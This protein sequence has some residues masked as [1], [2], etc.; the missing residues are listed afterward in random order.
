MPL[1][2]YRLLAVLLALAVVVTNLFRVLFLWQ[3]KLDAELWRRSQHLL[4]LA[5]RSF[6]G[7]W[8]CQGLGLDAEFF[9]PPFHRRR[10]KERENHQ[11]FRFDDE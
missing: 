9:A 10:G 8:K 1:S 3:D 5:V 2:L 7:W 6:R 4:Y 11:L